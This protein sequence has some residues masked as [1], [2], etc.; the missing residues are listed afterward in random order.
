MSEAFLLKISEQLLE[1][2]KKLKGR[3]SA[4]YNQGLKAGINQERDR[5]IKLLEDLAYIDDEYG[6]EMISEH[7]SELLELIKG[8]Q[9]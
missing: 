7:K 3:Q 5:I 6:Y 9:K 8:E 2:N 1:E 4:K